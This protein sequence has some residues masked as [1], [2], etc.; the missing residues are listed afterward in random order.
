[1]GV[2]T[3]SEPMDTHKSSST[4]NFVFLSCHFPPRFRF[5][6]ERLKKKG[7]NVLGIGDESY[8]NL[9][10]E[11]KENLREYFKVY[12]MEDYD[13]VYRAIGYFTHKY[14]RITFIESF[15]E[16]WLETEARLRED[17]NINEGYRPKE[18]AQFKRKSGM[19]AI[20]SGAGLKVAPGLLP[21][22]LEEAL[23]FAR[24]VGY[25]LIMKPD[26]GVGAEGAKKINDEAELTKNWDPKGNLFLE[27]FIV[28]N[29]ETYDGLCDHTGKIVFYS[30]LQYSA[31][32]MEVLTGQC[33][34]V[35]YYIV[36]DVPEDLK[37]LGDIA[38]K[39]FD[40]KSRF[41]HCEFFRT[42]DG[43]LLPLEINLRPPGGITVDIWNYT[44]RM[45][46]YEEYANVVTKQPTSPYK[47]ATQYGTYSARRD[48]WKYIHS[49]EEIE[50]KLGKRLELSYVMP[51]IFSPVM[52]NFAYVFTSD[53][54]EQMKEAVLFI[55][56]RATN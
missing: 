53:T 17:F 6:V 16:Y 22:T 7:V 38:V 32:I 37:A 5:F 29:I 2:Q 24:Q 10:H 35:F 33:E 15:N 27:Q 56:T 1:M 43:Q 13:Q 48:N 31:G 12:N 26:I 36:K 19:K 25:P 45:D 21:K 50:K 30:S 3:A 18:M 52:G 8:D 4:I 39:A 40:V 42:T 44:H 34:S 14:G 20:Y 9:H 46:L 55:E 23:Q 11:L 51:T 54:L 41:F 28:G 49:H 47:K